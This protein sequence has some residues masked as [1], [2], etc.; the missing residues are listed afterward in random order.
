MTDTNKV[1]AAKMLYKEGCD[2]ERDS[3]LFKDRAAQLLI[4]AGVK[5]D[6]PKQWLFREFMHEFI[7]QSREVQPT[8]CPVPKLRVV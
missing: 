1:L 5:T 2:M 7:R 8:Y 6:D 3:A 4:D